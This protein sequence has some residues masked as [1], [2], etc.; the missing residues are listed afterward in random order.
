MAITNDP[1]RTLSANMYYSH[2]WKNGKCYNAEVLYDEIAN[3]ISHFK[4]TQKALG[5]L[6][7]VSK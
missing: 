4:Y 6:D 1:R 2:F 7:K 5:P 3:K